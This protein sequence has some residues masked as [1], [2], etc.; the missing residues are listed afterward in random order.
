MSTSF[1]GDLGI[2]KAPT[3]RQSAER[4]S[5]EQPSL[6]RITGPE[7]SQPAAGGRLEVDVLREHP[8][9][10][11]RPVG[12]SE[13]LVETLEMSMDRMRRHPK[14]ARDVIFGLSEVFDDA[15]DDLKLSSRQLQ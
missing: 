7:R 14:V 3:R 4:A 1:F 2:A 15:C 11:V 12:D 13:L 9:D 10:Q 6:A 8:D 5:A